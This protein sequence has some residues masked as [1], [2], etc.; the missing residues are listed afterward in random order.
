MAKRVTLVAWVVA[1]LIWGQAITASADT[2]FTS[3]DFKVKHVVADIGA[4]ATV[5]VQGLIDRDLH[6]AQPLFNVHPSF[7]LRQSC[8]SLSDAAV[9]ITAT[10]TINW[11]F[12]QFQ[13]TVAVPAGQEGRYVDWTVTVSYD[14]ALDHNM[15]INGIC[16]SGYVPLGWTISCPPVCD[17]AWPTV[18]GMRLNIWPGSFLGISPL[19]TKK[20]ELLWVTLAFSSG[21]TEY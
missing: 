21:H 13:S 6:A 20:G 7:D 4:T 11:P 12:A 19:H 2:G 15:T 5:T 8:Q 18:T 14:P 1:L 16:P 9:T 3:N 10:A 17:I